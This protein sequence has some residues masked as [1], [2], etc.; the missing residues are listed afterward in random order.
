M[1]MMIIVIEWD[2][3]FVGNERTTRKGKLFDRRARFRMRNR[4][5]RN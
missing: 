2:E 5:K 1:I 3:N 4:V